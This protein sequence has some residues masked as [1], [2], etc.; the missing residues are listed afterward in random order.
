MVVCG[1]LWERKGVYL[2]KKD[3]YDD[4]KKEKRAYN[5]KNIAVLCKKMTPNI[6]EKEKIRDLFLFA[7]AQCSHGEEER[8]MEAGH[9]FKIILTQGHNSNQMS[10][11]CTCKALSP[12]ITV[13]EVPWAA[14][15]APCEA[16]CPFGLPD[17]G[18]D[19]TWAAAHHPENKALAQSSLQMKSTTQM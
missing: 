3:H 8:T 13:C 5:L 2:E 11:S 15:V 16:L 18:V 4:Y 19:S 9:L 1:L 14:W 10:G 6:K 12:L 7:S 17:K